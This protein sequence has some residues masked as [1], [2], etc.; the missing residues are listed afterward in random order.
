LKRDTIRISKNLIPYSFNI[1]LAGEVFEIG[2]KYNE[3][4]DLFTI[5]LTKDKELI[6]SG[7]PIVY[8][9]PLFQDIYVSGKY[10]ALK[11][12]PFDE[13]NEIKQVTWDNFEETVFLMIDN[14]SDEIG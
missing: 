11:I 7:E 2:I 3:Y 14:G 10:P 8:G 1:I 5:S 12:V 13:S 6:C 9:A 4:A